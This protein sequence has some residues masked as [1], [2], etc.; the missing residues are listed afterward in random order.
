MDLNKLP[1]ELSDVIRKEGD[2]RIM[3]IQ[4]YPCVIKRSTL[5]GLCGYVGVQPNNSIT[6][7]DDGDDDYPFYVGEQLDVHGGI[8]FTNNSLH[9]VDDSVFGKRIWFGFDCGHLGDL[10]PFQYTYNLPLPSSDIYR[11][12]EYVTEELKKL[13]QEI[14]D[15]ETN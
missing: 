2:F 11:T 14:I 6:E 12:M 7:I 10:I 3:L 15:Y 13:V 5:G 8:T 9:G 4:G 1:K